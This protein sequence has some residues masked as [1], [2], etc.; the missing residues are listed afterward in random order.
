MNRIAMALLLGA[1]CMTA[2][3]GVTAE[4]QNQPTV[5]TPCVILTGADSHVSDRE[6]HRITS[7]ND[8]AKLWQKHKGQKDNSEYDLYHDPLGLPLIDFQRYMVI[9]IFQGTRWNSAG[10][11]AVSIL[12]QQ[13]G[14]VFR[15][16]D[17]SYQT[18]GRN[19]GGRR[20]T[21]YGFFIVPRSPKPVVLEENVQ[22]VIGRPPEW[23]ER[24]TFPKL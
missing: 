12:E 9:A 6:Y 19:G 15:F 14:I 13:D 11:K 10:L 18:G 4:P 23:K 24:I 2:I 17:K 5:I 8:W 16:D 7:M 1:V 21:V 20:V 3:H 22:R